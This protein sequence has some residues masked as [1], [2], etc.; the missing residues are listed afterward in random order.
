AALSDGSGT[1]S[2]GLA[3]WSLLVIL[4]LVPAVL[5]PGQIGWA[6][7]AVVTG[8]FTVLD[9]LRLLPLLFLGLPFHVALPGEVPEELTRLLSLQLILSA[10][11]LAAYLLGMALAPPLARYRLP[12]RWVAKTSI[13]S[14]ALRVIFLSAAGSILMI[15]LRGGWRAHLVSLGFGRATSLAGDFY[16]VAALSV[17]TV[18]WLLWFASDPAATR[19]P[20][21]WVGAVASIPIPYLLSGSRSSLVAPLIV[22][23][24]IHAARGGRV[25]VRLVMAAGVVVVFMLGALAAVR[26]SVWRGTDSDASVLAN[27]DGTSAI[28]ALQEI[29]SRSGESSAILPILARVPGDVPPLYGQSY[30]ALMGIAVPRS[31]WP[32]KPRS[33]DGRVGETFFGVGFGIP[34]GG[35]GESFWNWGLAGVIVAFMA[36]GVIHRWAANLVIASGHSPPV[37]T[38][39]GFTLWLLRTPGS[40]SVVNWAIAVV[41]LIAV[42]LLAGRRIPSP[43]GGPP[44]A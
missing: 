21:F 28:R 35:L 6:H 42:A 23:G 1:T 14:L 5:S 9:C 33:V 40:P 38:A 11:A 8:M 25:M 12:G 27:V 15:F 44:D 13:A 3:G 34:P 16:A 30:L 36:L 37:L 18:A 43:G 24:I 19:R 10:L 41:P 29:T 31:F 26:E 7:P 17:G 32:G 22:A 20:S 2:I 4:A 39:Y